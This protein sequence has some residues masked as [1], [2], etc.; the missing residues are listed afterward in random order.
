MIDTFRPLRLA[1]TA[2]AHAD[3]GY[4]TSWARAHES[5]RL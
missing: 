5:G 1:S 3:R 2:V 4:L